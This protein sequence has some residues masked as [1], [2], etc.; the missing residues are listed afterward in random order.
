VLAHPRRYV[1]RRDRPRRDRESLTLGRTPVT[2]VLAGLAVAS[3]ALVLLLPYGGRDRAE[4]SYDTPY[5]VW[6]TRAVATEGLHVLTEIPTGAV[7]ERPGFP[8]LGAMVGAITGLDALTFSVVVR[9]V[10]AIAIGLAAGAMAV[11]VLGQPRWVF[12]AFVIGVGASAAVVGTAIGSLD[13]LLADIVLVAAATTAALAAAGRAGVAATAVLLAASAATHWVFTGLFLVLL[14]GTVAVL[15][16]GSL[17]ERRSGTT[18]SATSSARLLRVLGVASA[19]TIA[20]LALLPALPDHL[21]PAVGQKGN[22]LRLGAYELPWL[23]PLAVVGFVL[24]FRRSG[25]SRKTAVLLLGLWAATVPLAMA[26][27]AILPTPLKLFRVAPFALGVPVL[28]TLGLVT[29]ASLSGER[30][31]RWGIVLGS[32]ILV[33]GLLWTSG[34]PAASFSDAGGGRVAGVM[35]QARTAGRYL[36]GVPRDGRPVVFVTIGPPRLVDRAVRSGVPSDMIAETW[37][38]VGHPD[39]LAA[40]GPVSDPAR[41]RLSEMARAWWDQ[42]W[43]RPSSVLGKDPIVIQIGPAGR[44]AVGTTELGPGVAIVRGPA[45]PASFGSAHPVGFG[46]IQVLIATALALIVL[47]AAGGGWAALLLDASMLATVGLAPAF[48]VA[49]LVLVGTGAGRFDLPL[50]GWAGIS[51]LLATAGAGWIFLGAREHILRIVKR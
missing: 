13:Q 17:G 33:G 24:A 4:L 28:A 20:T 18:W 50:G 12:A 22:L 38:F 19:A 8:V 42:A 27:S 46:W 5:Y 21:P 40:G 35:T 48:G 29:L 47:A 14:L 37:V 7:P 30:L 34:S 36:E 25:S 10:A 15:V 2:A 45:P 39:D 11:E 1:P 26:I 23:L 49:A 51:V 43:T 6:R 44:R 16:P 41:P 31:G 9:A 3:V 32:F